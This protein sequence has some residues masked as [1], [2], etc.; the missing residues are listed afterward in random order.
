GRF[1]PDQ[2][3]ACFAGAG[4]L[5]QQI[6]LRARGQAPGAFR[7]PEDIE[8]HYQARREEARRL[9]YHLLAYPDVQ[10]IEWLG[11][12]YPLDS[13]EQLFRR[14]ADRVNAAEVHVAA[15]VEALIRNRLAPLDAE[16]YGRLVKASKKASNLH[17]FTNT[18]WLRRLREG[19]AVA[20]EVRRLLDAERDPL[21][22]R[23]I[24][25]NRND[26]E[27]LGLLPS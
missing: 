26:F 7:T 3:L 15:A 14:V 23:V 8:R 19:G 10:Q 24:R 21:V 25:T 6:L 17:L 20:E 16:E 11:T 18:G 12:V 1:D 2:A 22:A 4:I 9:S 27:R 5:A 13:D